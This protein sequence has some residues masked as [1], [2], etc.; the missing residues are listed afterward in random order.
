[1]KDFDR[2]MKEAL[3]ERVRTWSLPMRCLKI[4]EKR[5]MREERRMVL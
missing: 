5:R 3:A 1:M 2:M 4:S